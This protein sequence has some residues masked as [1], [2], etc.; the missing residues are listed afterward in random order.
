MNQDDVQVL[1]RDILPSI[2]HPVGFGSL[3]V[4]ERENSL[5]EDSFY[6]TIHMTP[7]AG[8]GVSP[9]F[10]DALVAMQDALLARGERR[11]AYMKYD[12]PSDPPPSADDQ[13]D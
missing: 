10:G 1:A 6:V 7:E 2:L 13:D 5:G 12:L 3:D 4:V 9:A 8:Y 11:F